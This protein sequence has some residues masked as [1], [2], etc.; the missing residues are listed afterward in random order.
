LFLSKLK[1]L[2][3]D[4]QPAPAPTLDN[5]VSG[6]N[7]ELVAALRALPKSELGKRSLYLW[8]LSGS[9]RTHLLKATVALFR[10]Q[11]LK[12]EYTR[13]N[14]DWD[15]LSTCDV[16]ALDDVEALDETAQIALFNLFNRLREAGKVL[17]VAGPCAPM[18]LSLRD[19]LKTRLGWSMVYQAQA[20]SDPEKSEALQHHAADRGF[21][22]PEEVVHY[23]LRHVRRDLPSLMSMLDALDEWSLTAKRP[24]TVPLLRQWL[25]LPLKLD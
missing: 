20:L 24:I 8:G 13:E 2:L 4:I 7:S 12:A 18:E 5:F 3:L 15:A 25:Q 17:I 11:G 23:L 22:L 21:R 6:R 19:D 16:V 1:Q 9:G 14:A 10:Q